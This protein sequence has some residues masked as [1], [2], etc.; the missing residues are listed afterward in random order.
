MT[1]RGGRQ[2]FTQAE[3]LL[4]LGGE[5]SLK[6]HQFLFARIQL[7][8]SF[9]QTLFGGPEFL[10]SQCVTG[11]GGRQLFAQAEELV[12]LGSEGGLKSH[13]FLFAGIQLC[14]SGRPAAVRWPS[15]PAVARRD[16]LCWPS[17]VRAGRGTPAAGQ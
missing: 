4:L 6:S 1:G 2:L 7:G 10:L 13:Q 8:F 9:G 16:W 12:M 14:F 11:C 5:G 17:I 15:V 3:E